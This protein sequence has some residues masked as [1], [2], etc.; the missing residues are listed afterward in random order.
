MTDGRCITIGLHDCVAAVAAVFSALV[1][2]VAA[3]FVVSV[4]AVVLAVVFGVAV[5]SV[6]A[7]VLAFIAVA[8]VG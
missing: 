6:A 4:A 1:G 8:L 2:V 5:V 3:L 7:V